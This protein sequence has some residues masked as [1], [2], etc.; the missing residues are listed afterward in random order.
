MYMS[1]DGGLLVSCFDINASS[2]MSKS[3][4]G[5][6]WKNVKHCQILPHIVIIMQDNDCATI[7]QEIT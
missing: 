7:S 1:R 4:N 5:V 6:M 3:Y 2:L